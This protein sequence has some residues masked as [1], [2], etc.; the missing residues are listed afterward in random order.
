V[1]AF[2]F[3]YR[4][5]AD[6]PAAGPEVAAAW[7]AFLDGLGPSLADAGNPVFERSTAGTATGTVLG[8]YSI[9]TAENLQAAARLAEGCPYV[10]AGGGVEVGELTLLNPA[11]IATT[12][13][14]HARATQRTP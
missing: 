1:S 6:Y 14:D 13:G 12:A 3:A 10:A 4:V 5:P 8:G 11:S 7:Q 9:I 2:L